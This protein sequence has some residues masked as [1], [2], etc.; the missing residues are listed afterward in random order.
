MGGLIA[1]ALDALCQRHAP[2]VER[3]AQHVRFEAVDFGYEGNR[4]I[5]HGVSF[6]VGAN[7]VVSL[8][9]ALPPQVEVAGLQISGVGDALRTTVALRLLRAEGGP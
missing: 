4:Q 2:R 8:L 3:L 5:L 7:E 1:R 6:Q 9:G